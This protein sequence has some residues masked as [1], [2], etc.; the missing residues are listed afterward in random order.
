MAFFDDF[1]LITYL[2]NINGREEL[3]VVKDITRNIRVKKAILANILLYEDY[4]IIDGDTPE[5]IAEK[6]YGDPTL[7]WVIMLT[8]DR[9]SNITDFPLSNTQLERYV[10]KKYANIWPINAVNASA[11]VVFSNFSYANIGTISIAGLTVTS[12]GVRSYTAS[13]ISTVIT[14]G[15]VLG[16]SISGLA[17]DYILSSGA[18]GSVIFTSIYS[19]MTIVTLAASATGSGSLPSA[20]ISINSV[21]YV[22]QRDIQH[23]IYGRPHF[24]NQAGKIISGKNAVSRVMFGNPLIDIPSVNIEYVIDP[25]AIPVSNYEYEFSINEAKRRIVLIHPKLI[26]RLLEDLKTAVTDTSF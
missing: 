21:A 15:T 10:E 13:E 12:N 25:L 14:G 6:I 26:P 5:R 17:P 16:L 4:D 2:Y 7:H 8:N 9:F 3:R 19:E 22:A 24:I 20:I 23:I 18:P 1:P 11:N